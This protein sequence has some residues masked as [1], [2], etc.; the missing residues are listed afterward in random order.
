MSQTANDSARMPAASERAAEIRERVLDATEECIGRFGVAKTTLGDVAKA[1]SISR[2]TVYRHFDGRDALLLGVMQR[3]ANRMALDAMREL[4][5]IESVGEFMV[6]GMLY[7]L[8]EIPRRPE[9]AT[10]FLA[11]DS[12]AAS[13]VA[14]SAE[15]ILQVGVAL[16][17]PVLEPARAAGM[18]RDDVRIEEVIEWSIRLLIS[19][20]MTPS[21]V[22]K[23]DE[24]MRAMLRRMMIPAVV[25]T[26]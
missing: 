13:R 10:L 24:E 6:E 15:Q 26:P 9:L 2:A 23:S 7:A 5:P 8:R 3:G 4:M 1:A 17:L 20:L 16:L 18:L 14:L 11:N 12:S 19:Y 25:K 22:A 21:L